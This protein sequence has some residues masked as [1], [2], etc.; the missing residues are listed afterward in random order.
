[1]TLAQHPPAEGGM[2]HDATVEGPVSSSTVA[3]MEHPG[4]FR[5]VRISFF[6]TVIV[7]G[8]VALGEA[9]FP[10]PRKGINLAQRSTTAWSATGP[11]SV[12]R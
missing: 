12:P 5:L 7:S 2:R 8:P 3:S 11:S 6:V 9:N 1:M 10:A 4:L